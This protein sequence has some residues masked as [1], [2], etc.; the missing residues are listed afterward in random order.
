MSLE[1]GLRYFWLVYVNKILLAALHINLTVKSA[2]I[3]S[4]SSENVL[5]GES[6]NL[7]MN[8]FLQTS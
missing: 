3:I 6:V 4:C 7:F 5:S 2:P 1:L 8:F